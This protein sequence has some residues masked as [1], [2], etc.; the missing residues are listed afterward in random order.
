M[1]TTLFILCL[2][3]ATAAFGQTASVL[4]NNSQPIQIYGNPQ[5]ASQH[6]LAQPQDILEHSD[7]TYAKGERPLSEFGMT[8]SEPTPLGD[9]ARA[10]RKEHASARKADIVFE[11]YVAAKK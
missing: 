8:P 4:P 6:E 11:K 1:K 7:Y 10:Y 9:I 2:I 3:C 5:H